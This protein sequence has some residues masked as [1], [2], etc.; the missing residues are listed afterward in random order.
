MKSCCRI[1]GLLVFASM[2]LKGYAAELQPLGHLPEN[3][4]KHYAL[5]VNCSKRIND[6]VNQLQK[7]MITKQCEEERVNFILDNRVFKAWRVYVYQ[8]QELPNGLRVVFTI[9]SKAPTTNPF[10]EST[11]SKPQAFFSN[12]HYEFLI[13]ESSPLFADIASLAIGQRVEI[14]GAISDSTAE[15]NW[16]FPVEI[17]TTIRLDSVR[18]Y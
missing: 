4:L 12:G 13:K 11:Y 15:S 17:A 2:S 14:D 18:P 10:L 8:I 7:K 5:F 16:E 3:Q 9:P 6:G 1:I